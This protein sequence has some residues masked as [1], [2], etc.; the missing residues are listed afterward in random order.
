MMD[1]SIACGTIGISY[2]ANFHELL[3]GYGIHSGHQLVHTL[4]WGGLDHPHFAS[5]VQVSYPGHPHTRPHPCLDG[6]LRSSNLA[7]GSDSLRLGGCA[8]QLGI[9]GGHPVR[10]VRKGERTSYAGLQ[11]QFTM[12]RVSSS[13]NAKRGW[14]YSTVQINREA[15]WVGVN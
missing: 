2:L 10:G 1:H 15:R 7:D 8:I 13:S 5:R 3:L 12:Y 11:Q 9:L 6:C 14:G 4:I